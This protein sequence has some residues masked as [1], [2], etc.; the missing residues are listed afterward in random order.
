MVSTIE[1]MQVKLLL[2]SLSCL[3]RLLY[4]I[5]DTF[6]YIEKKK[7]ICMGGGWGKKYI[8]AEQT[9]YIFIEHIKIEERTVIFVKPT[10][11]FT[12]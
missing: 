7:N 8:S 1:Q 12:K 4:V 9:I 6:V 3:H 10:V 11:S 5:N 2:T